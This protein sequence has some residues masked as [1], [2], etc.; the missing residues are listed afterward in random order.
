MDVRIAKTDQE[1]KDAYFIRR[2]VFIEEQQVPEEIEVDEQ[3]QEA[4]HFI[5]YD[6][7]EPIGAGRMRLFDDYGKAERVSVLASSRKKGVGELIMKKMEETALVEGKSFVKLN[8]QSHAEP[9]YLKIG[10]ET[11]SDVFYEADI[12]HVAM[13]KKI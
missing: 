12:P 11:C 9:F 5:A 1:L 8:A 2:V 13:K 3:E 6:N 7:G 10:Y 4:I